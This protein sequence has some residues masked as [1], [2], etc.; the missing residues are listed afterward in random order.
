MTIGRTIVIA[1]M[2]AAIP[3]SAHSQVKDAQ[4]KESSGARDG[5][6]G[7]V[8]YGFLVKQTQFG[9]RGPGLPGHDRCLKFL[10]EELR[11]HADAV[12]TQDFPFTLPAGNRV[13]LTNLMATF[14][15]NATNRI[16]I[17]AHWDTRLWADRDPDKKN[18][19]K[20]IAGANDGASGVAIIL[21]IARQL[22][23]KPPSVGVDLLLFDGE[24]LGKTGKPESF[25]AGSKYFAS[26]LPAGFHARFGINIDMVGDRNLEIY[27]EQGSE[28]MAPEVQNLVFATARKLNIPA[29]NNA[30][31]EEV[32]DDHLPL[33]N[34]GIP[35]IDLIDF[36]YPDE[37][38]KY[39]HTLADTPDK[40][41]AA[42]LSAVGRVL[43]DILY[44]Q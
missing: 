43:M 4:P 9:P 39:W 32:T 26:N 6:D 31:G 41:S 2:L 25:S 10:R 27:R 1:A 19:D 14:N 20:P 37:S 40:C 18:W 38:N 5:F 36:R 11:K 44:S 34:V 8:A 24:D 17:S 16:L 13:Q 12:L 15:P 35:T 30:L 7:T 23:M 21:E 22:R 29:F 3:P 42:S 33:N 28:Q